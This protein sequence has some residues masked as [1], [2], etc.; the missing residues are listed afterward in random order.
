MVQIFDQTTIVDVSVNFGLQYWSGIDSLTL[1]AQNNKIDIK[2]ELD[3]KNDG[4]HWSLK[5]SFENDLQDQ[6][7]LHNNLL[8]AAVVEKTEI[9]LQTLLQCV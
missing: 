3:S 9:F 4:S 7:N 1:S 2:K 6:K 8:V 5:H